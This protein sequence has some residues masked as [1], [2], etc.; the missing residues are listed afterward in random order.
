MGVHFDL[1]SCLNLR[2]LM[3][4]SNLLGKINF[5]PFVKQEFSMTSGGCIVVI[6]LFHSH[7]IKGLNPALALGERMVQQSKL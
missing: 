1:S 3:F 4:R 5:V 2:V 7:K 6:H